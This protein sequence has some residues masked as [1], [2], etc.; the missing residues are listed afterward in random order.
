MADT[1]NLSV[2]N[3]QMINAIYKAA[4]S[5][6]HNGWDL[7]ARAGLTGLIQN[8]QGPYRGP[9]IA[10]LPGLTA[11][12]K[13]LVG[14]AL[15]L[16]VETPQPE[17]PPPVARLTNQQM[18]NAIYRAAAALGKNGW[19]LLRRAGLISLVRDRQAIYEGP[20]INALPGLSDAEKAQ[21]RIA[22]GLPAETVP[23]TVPTPSGE[24]TH[25][26][27]INAIYEVAKSA[28]MNG[29][30]LLRAAGLTHLVR[31]R[32]AIYRGTAIDSLPG[33]SSSQKAQVKAALSL[34]VEI[35]P[36]P[37]PTP[38]SPPP[39]RRITNQQ[40]INAIYEVAHATGQRGWDL[41]ARA[42][43]TQLAQDRTGDYTGPAVDNLP[44]LSTN[45]KIRLKEAL[46]LL[47]EELPKPAIEE[48]V[49]VVTGIEG[50]IRWQGPSPNQETTRYGYP[51]EMIVMHYTASGSTAG[52]VSWFMNPDSKVSAHYIV[53]RDGEIAQVVKD[54]MRAH[55]AGQ[56]PL[57]GQSEEV[58]ERRRIRN[59]V[60]QP[61]SR[62]VGIEI[63]NWGPLEKRG[64]KY[65][66]W[67]GNECPGEVVRKG[68]TYWQAYT[69][70][71]L[72]SVIRLVS[73]LCKKHGIPAQYPSQ[74]PGQFDPKDET[75]A[76]FKGIL[77]HSALDNQKRDP[78]PHFDWDRLLT[79][80]RK[81]LG[82]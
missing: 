37:P 10:A 32:Q 49:I 52:T 82:Q 57:A 29:W 15:G 39:V 8:R 55:H 58:G 35:V 14:G 62:S 77:G 13:A 16:T 75:L 56:G 41:L 66:T 74:G 45:E 69:E 68:G 80:V 51:I 4:R 7:L 48:E 17:A 79:S 9:E 43:L 23:P 46:G 6:G 2:T 28:G 76:S 54:E 73:H 31:D 78:G 20:E 36:P 40:M 19:D 1:S 64:D 24:F 42:R 59:R 25:Q 18:I 30:S 81:S 63:V 72:N 3:Q 70:T 47:V 44:G 53:G 67:M 26:Q 27:L 5:V 65:Y 38:P 61:N 11:Q 34:P 71:Q 21:V 12:E 50:Q 33:L 22:L 60:I